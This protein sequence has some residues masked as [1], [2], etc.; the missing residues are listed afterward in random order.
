MTKIRIFRGHIPHRCNNLA[1]AYL[2]IFLILFAGCQIDSDK[3]VERDK[4]LFKTGDDT[5]L[6]FK[7]VRQSD[8]DLETNEAAKF[9]VFR[10]EDRPLEDSVLWITPAIVMN[11]LQDEA[12]ILL[13]PSQLLVSEDE[14]V[15]VH[16]A[17]YDTLRLATPN[18]EENLEFASRIY[19]HIKTGDTLL[20]RTGNKYKPFLMDR[21]EAE[22]FRVTMGDY[23]RLT[24]IF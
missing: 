9:N 23:Y 5:E 7:N 2:L 14:L 20:I 11:Y 4:F 3:K 15:V 17:S 16:A 19:E 6:F 21:T 10:H 13:E 8:Y 1:S 22:I 18:R 24:R 12:Y